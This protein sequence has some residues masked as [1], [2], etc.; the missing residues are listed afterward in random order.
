M[1]YVLLFIQKVV[2]YLSN[3]Y[4]LYVCT[5]VLDKYLILLL[6]VGVT[7]MTLLCLYH[8]NWSKL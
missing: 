2:Q 3:N 4:I 7:W 5:I 6:D 8:D 1:H